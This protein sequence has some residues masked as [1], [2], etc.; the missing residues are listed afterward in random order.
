MSI[1]SS[2]PTRQAIINGSRPTVLSFIA[3]RASADVPITVNAGVAVPLSAHYGTLVAAQAVYPHATALSNSIAWAAIRGMLLAISDVGRGGKCVVTAGEWHLGDSL[4]EIPPGV[5]L[6]I[7]GGTLIASGDTVVR[8]AGSWRSAL[9]VGAGATLRGGKIRLADNSRAS[10]VIYG[11]DADGVVIENVEIDGS[12]A[13][14]QPI[15]GGGICL[16][17]TARGTVRNCY[18]HDTI[19]YAHP[20]IL[21]ADDGN[22]YARI[23]NCRVTYS[24]E[25]GDNAADGIYVGAAENV[26]VTGCTVDRA[27][28]TGVVLEAVSNGLIVGCTFQECAQAVSIGSGLVGYAARANVI[29]ACSVFGGGGAVVGPDVAMLRVAKLGGNA[30]LASVIENCVVHDVTNAHGAWLDGALGYTIANCSFNGID[31]AGTYHG[32]YIDGS[33]DGTISGCQ[34]LGVG[35]AGIMLKNARRTQIHGNIIR[36]VARTNENAAGIFATGDYVSSLHCVGN[37]IVDSNTTIASKKMAAAISTGDC[38]A[39]AKWSITSLDCWDGT[40]N[41]GGG[42]NGNVVLT[43]LDESVARHYSDIVNEGHITVT[44]QVRGLKANGHAHPLVYMVED[45][46]RLKP[47]ATDKGIQ[48]V[49]V[50][51]SDT[52]LVVKDD[53]TSAPM[54]LRLAPDVAVQSTLSGDVVNL[55]AQADGRTRVFGNGAGVQITDA[56]AS[57]QW[58]LF[59]AAALT[60]AGKLSLADGAATVSA[61]AADPEG[62][63]TAPAGS[64]YLRT[65]GA[66][67]RKTSG[68]GDTGWTADTLGAAIWSSLA[69]SLNND[70]AVPA[71]D[72]AG[73]ARSI[74]SLTADDFTRLIAAGSAGVQITNQ[75]Q[76]EAWLTATASALLAGV[77]FRSP[78]GTAYQSLIAGDPKNLLVIADGL[79]RILAAASGGVQITDQAASA[80]WALFT[81]T[82]LALAGTIAPSGGSMT[83][84]SGTAS[85]EGAITAPAGSLYMR[86]DG[87]LWRKA[88]GSGNTGWVEMDAAS[89]WSSLT[90]ALANNSFVPAKDSGGTTRSLVGITTDDFTRI[91]AAGSAGIQLT[92]AAA[93]AQWALF[94]AA[95]SSLAV[96]APQGSTARIYA[97]ASGPESTVTASRGSIFLRTDGQLW[98]KTTGDGTNTGW[99]QITASAVTSVAGRTGAVT[100]TSADV[101]G[102]EVTSAKNAASGYA[103]LDGNARIAAARLPTGTVGHFLKGQGASDPVYAAISASDLPSTINISGEYQVGS[104]KVVGARGAAVA[105]PSGGAT[106]DTECRTQL[107]A[108]LARLRT[109]GLIAT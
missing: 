28:D 49:N 11:E 106:V 81:A 46:V 19:G 51:E 57:A 98:L 83:L 94:T 58:A 14:H 37:T 90:G 107:S 59:T 74:L 63:I 38:A 70:Q 20:S 64:I 4:L 27:A 6:L 91:L 24:G 95:L 3:E 60:L 15:K 5:E 48:F 53:H 34:I 67:Y 1:L 101:S 65:N 69:G 32:I 40:N 31:E 55:I 93:S 36:D 104:A 21:F 102:V 22:D 79:T 54:P 76:S 30:P 89:A 87:A 9:K 97:G 88:S 56:G 41:A 108:L 84:S 25:P 16:S 66:F 78:E 100:L 42:R 96:V 105:D 85:P 72:S 8:V 2:V 44:K 68:S 7:D 80:Q 86:S 47:T 26:V 50:S 77:P 75:A 71:K 99:T 92:D 18:V 39:P 12:A 35:G 33:N 23:E 17:S 61:G 73:T 62:A 109:H 29:S 103:G 43:N 13:T 45:F 52:V 82:A 10:W